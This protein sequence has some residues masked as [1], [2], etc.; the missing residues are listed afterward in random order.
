MQVFENYLF[1]EREINAAS[2]RHAIEIR[3]GG[4]SEH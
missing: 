3:S 2:C 4:G 1:K